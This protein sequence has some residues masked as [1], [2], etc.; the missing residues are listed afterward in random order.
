LR[1]FMQNN[2]RLSSSF[3]EKTSCR[4]YIAFYYFAVFIFASFSGNASVAD[5]PQWGGTSHRNMSSLEKG[6]P[7]N[8]YPGKKQREGL[9]RAPTT[10]KNVRWIVRLGFQNYS[11]PVIANGRVF[12]GT[13]DEALD[14]PL[15]KR[16]GGGVLM[17]LDEAT[18]KLN[19]QLVVPRLQIDRSKV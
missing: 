17:C 3:L 10:A 13:N 9:G 12:I 11:S 5:W 14:D 8:F 2:T 1:C 15:F 19:W 6:L 16:T 7:A 18:G 4:P